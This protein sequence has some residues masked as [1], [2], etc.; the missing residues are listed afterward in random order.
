MKVPEQNRYIRLPNRCIGIQHYERSIK[1]T[2]TLPLESVVPKYFVGSKN[3]IKE[4]LLAKTEVV[5]SL[6]GGKIFLQ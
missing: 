6:G 2:V 3:V 5:T 4:V 1:Q